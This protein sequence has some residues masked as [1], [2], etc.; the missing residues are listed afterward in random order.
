LLAW[1]D[2]SRRRPPICSRRVGPACGGDHAPTR[3]ANEGSRRSKAATRASDKP[4][5]YADACEVTHMESMRL[6]R[7][8]AADR[9]ADQPLGLTCAEPRS[10]HSVSTPK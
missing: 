6:V 1:P 9:P 10:M 7:C 3:P 5:I 2:L 4:L 8:A